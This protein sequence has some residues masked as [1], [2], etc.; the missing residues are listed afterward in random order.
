MQLVRFAVL[1]LTPFNAQNGPDIHQQT[2]RFRSETA[3]DGR[4]GRY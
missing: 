1:S 4:S 3:L 2:P